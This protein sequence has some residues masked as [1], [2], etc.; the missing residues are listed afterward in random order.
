MIGSYG[1]VMDIDA[2]DNKSNDRSFNQI[3]KNETLLMVE[4]Q[5]VEDC[6]ETFPVV[7]A[8]LVP[9]QE[10]LVEDFKKSE[11]CDR[12]KNRNNCELVAEYNLLLENNPDSE[13]YTY[14]KSAIRNCVLNNF[15][16]ESREK[17]DYVKEGI[18]EHYKIE[19]DKQYMIAEQTKDRWE[20]CQP[21]YI[22]APTGSGKNTF[23]EKTLIPY[24]RELNIK[25]ETDYKILIIGN[26]RALQ[27]QIKDRTKKNNPENYNENKKYL[28]NY[29]YENHLYDGIA[30][31]VLYQSVL[32]LEKKL[33]KKQNTRKEK[34]LFV[35]CDEA[36]FFTSDSSFN[37]YTEKILSAITRIFKRAI[38]I[39]MTA[40]PYESFKVIE[41]YERNIDFKEY[42][43]DYSV[44]IQPNSKYKEFLKDNKELQKLIPR[45]TYPISGV[46]YHFKRNF[47]FLDIKYYSDKK[48][49]TP[50][51]SM[52][53]EK[54]LIFIDDIDAGEKYKKELEKAGIDKVYA[55]NAESKTDE[56]YQQMIRKEIF[57]R[58]LIATSVVDNGVNFREVD[59]VVLSDISK[60]KCMQ[61]LGR[62]R[63]DN[64]KD[65]IT[66][67]LKRFDVEII[68]DRI[69]YLEKYRK[70]ILDY[71]RYNTNSPDDESQK[72]INYEWIFLNR[73][74]NNKPD[75]WNN[76]KHWFGR[77]LKIPTKL[78]PNTIMQSLVEESK[79]IYESILKEMAF[80]ISKYEL[81]GQVAGQKYLEYQL[82]WFGKEFDVDND[83]TLVG[84]DKA[85]NEFEDFLDSYAEK[86]DSVEDMNSD[87]FKT[88]RTIFTSKHDKAYKSKDNRGK[89]GYGPVIIK[90][91]L[92]ENNLNYALYKSNERP[93]LYRIIR[94]ED[95]PDKPYS[96]KVDEAIKKI[97]EHEK[98]EKN[99]IKS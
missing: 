66:L 29:S 88:F 47:N 7:Q 76:A 11:K 45:V 1:F 42:A 57:P 94:L 40:T 38:R 36:H 65:R 56:D 20:P 21:I 22:S 85:I 9:V 67:Y 55:I 16:I 44:E 96:I 50:I 93:T 68:N 97:K 69:G 91:V 92:E 30:E 70:A 33:T 77:D 41:Q 80:S 19:I 78:F 6:N 37:P 31:V 73:Y 81:N 39:Y 71:S 82:S 72:K 46:C 5:P 98:Q 8:Q 62:A 26:R 61:M 23:V 4:A 99:N 84:H 34:Y 95:N 51:I 53:N 83:I 12:C 64:P 10:Q 74:Y 63:L 52:S 14:T 43:N 13:N 59:N 24:V 27:M 79:L 60:I 35:V 87:E 48:E 17:K 18:G 15:W 86:T 49:L 54:W 25:K 2:T 28:Y 75:D 58:I 3:T 32:S 90:K 89:D